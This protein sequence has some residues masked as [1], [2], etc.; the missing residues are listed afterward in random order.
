[1]KRSANYIRIIATEFSRHTKIIKKNFFFK[2]TFFLLTISMSRARP[3][4]FSSN[5]TG[6]KTSYPLRKFVCSMVLLWLFI[7]MTDKKINM[8]ST[9]RIHSDTE[10]AQSLTSVASN[11]FLFFNLT[12]SSI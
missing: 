11:K 8:S 6:T 3:N 12:I 5:I 7:I 10:T 4:C 9:L 1:M 2:H